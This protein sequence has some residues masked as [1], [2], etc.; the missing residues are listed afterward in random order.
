[1]KQINQDPYVIVQDRHGGK[2]SVYFS[3]IGDHEIIFTDNTN[4]IFYKEDYPECPIQAVEQA[5]ID[6]ATGKRELL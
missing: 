4:H 6:W 1:M 5:A 3:S 2:A